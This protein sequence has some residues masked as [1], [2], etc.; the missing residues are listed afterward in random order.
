MGA[1][2]MLADG[3]SMASG[4]FLGTRAEN[5][6]ADRARRDEEREIEIHPR[7]ER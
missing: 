3:F 5:Q 2:N 7:G 6:A 1:A 4:N